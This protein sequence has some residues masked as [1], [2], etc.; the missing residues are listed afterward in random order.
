MKVA[1]VGA[2]ISGLAA[3]WELHR[4]AEVTIFEPARLGGKILTE[5]FEGRPVDCGPDAF[6]TRTADAIDLCQELQLDDLV[7]PQAGRTLLWWQD[8]LRA[9]PDGLVL[10][11]P[12]RLTP[13]LGAR[14]LSPVGL[15]R[16]A[17]D[18]VLPGRALAGDVSVRELV[19]RR[20]GAQVA[21]RLVDP[22]VGGIHAGRT[23]NLSAE[24]TVPQL[25]EAARK[26]RSLLLG[27]RRLTPAVAN[28]GPPFLTPRR[29]LGDLV[30]RI[31]HRLRAGG[32]Q[33]SP[34]EVRSLI[35]DG[36]RW[37][38]EPAGEPFDAVVLAA[39]STAAAAILGPGAPAGLSQ[40]PAVSVAL[41]TL[42]YPQLDLPSACNG[43]LVPPAA[44]RLMT[45]CSFASAKWP[46]W[47]NPGRTI[48]RLSVGRDQDTRG[49]GLS[50]E[51]LA[52]RLADE[53][54]RMLHLRSD[55][56]TWRVSRWPNSFPQYRVGHTAMVGR[57][58]EELRR[59]HPNVTIC[60]AS[61]HGA[62]IPACIS[63][64][65]AAARS[66]RRAAGQP[67]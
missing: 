67:A 40:I 28:P 65:R 47:A 23:A 19:L 55:P 29:G 44:G 64:G 35:P 57:I 8:R 38:I 14:L 22:L 41:A 56:D 15:L 30:E 37:R 59:T 60:G 1:V 11:V 25:M 12:R 10:G 4:D 9:L 7:A 20:F 58:D 42:G 5:T 66:V 52:E 16:A 49:D 13:L 36:R 31:V 18:L 46:H 61:F 3:A 39:G 27:L 51:Q 53:V 34:M 26:S 48:L 6:I 43:V 50:D 21:D 62:G 63:S 24:A 32:V 45:A 2:G 33:V 54:R 17:G